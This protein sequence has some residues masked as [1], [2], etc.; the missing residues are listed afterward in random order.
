MAEGFARKLGGGLLE[1]WSAGSRPSGK[2][3]ATAIQL[4]KEKGIELDA[5]ASKGFDA[6]PKSEW[7]CVVTMGC[8]DQCPFVPSAETLDWD[9]PDP[10]AMP[11]EE[12]RRVR[13]FIEERVSALV[14]EIAKQAA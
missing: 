3:N 2:V 10:K 9:I 7:D 1:A 11:L 13:D 12:F 14:R 5:C 4:M 8:G 6:L